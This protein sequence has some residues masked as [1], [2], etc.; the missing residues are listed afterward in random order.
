[1]ISVFVSVCIAGSFAILSEEC[2]HWFVVPLLICGS[3]IGIDA[4]DWITGRLDIYDPVGITGIYGYHFFFTAPLL[5]VVWDWWAPYLT[6]PDDWRVWVGY[7]AVLNAAGLLIYRFIHKS[8][9]PRTIAK[10]R[11]IWSLSYSKISIMTCSLMTLSLL[12]QVGVY[13]KFGGISGY[14]SAYERRDQGFENLGIIFAVSECF[15]VMAILYY[16]SKTKSLGKKPSWASLGVVLLLFIAAKVF[17]GGLRGSRANYIWPLFWAIGTIHFNIRPISRKMVASGLI[18]F[19]VFMYAYGFFKNFGG[20]VLNIFDASARADMAATS[21][22]T[23]DA[24]LLGDLGR[25]DVQSLMLSRLGDPEV[26]AGYEYGLG[27]TYLGAVALLIPR[28]IY[29]DRPPTKARKG[30]E[31]LLARGS[32]VGFDLHGI[33]TLSNAYGL[34][35]EAMLNFGV[36]GVIPSFIVLGMFVGRVKVWV[37]GLHAGDSRQLFAPFIISLCFYCL[38]WDSDVTVFYIVTS[39]AMLVGVV[40]GCSYIVAASSRARMCT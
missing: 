40:T 24:M 31:L 6:P 13:A 22:L 10:S 15:P 17:F 23:F 28:W 33:E 1:M 27:R 8:I 29:P 7:M 25:A 16:I 32:G 9:V 12:L 38:V 34:A 5:H 3:I 18:F 14:V 4:V 39:G 20:N 36:W 11:T 19:V 37:S 35:G 2:Q 21:L 30:T 26:H